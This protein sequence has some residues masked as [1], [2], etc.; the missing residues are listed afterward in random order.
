MN[1]NTEGL[2]N[3]QKGQIG[4][5]YKQPILYWGKIPEQEKSVEKE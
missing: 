1:V 3:E 2:P 5:C 4:L